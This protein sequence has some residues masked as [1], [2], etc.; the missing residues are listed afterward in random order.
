[1]SD[2]IDEQLDRLEAEAREVEAALEE[3]KREA[4]EL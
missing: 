4:A 2:P 1:M 3:L